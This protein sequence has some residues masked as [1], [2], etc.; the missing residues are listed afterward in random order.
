MN[1]LNQEKVD[2]MFCH[3]NSYGRPSLS[4]KSPAVLFLMLYGDSLGKKLGVKP[5]D[6]PK[7][8]LTPTLIK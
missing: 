7:I 8:N 1:P 5:I 3:I 2:L 6:P 4:N